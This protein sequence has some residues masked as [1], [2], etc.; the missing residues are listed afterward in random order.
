MEKDFMH[1]CYN[2]LLNIDATQRRHQVEKISDEI[3]Q[4]TLG[5]KGLAARLLLE[6]NPPKVDP[7]SP[8]NHLIF[9]IG[10]ATGTS[11]WGSCRYGVFTKSPQTGYF[12]ESYSGGTVGTRMAQTGYDAVSITGASPDPVWIEISDQEVV[13]HD[14]S[15]LMGLETFETEDRVKA[16]VK[17]NRPDTRNCGVVTIGPAGENRVRFAVIEN[18]YWRSA[19]RT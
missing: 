4:S 18:D 10:P 3:L 8:D 9:A 19:G 11:I 1:G 14:A 7:F 6:R 16:W 5:G 13:F 12:S 2:T 15:E 17:E